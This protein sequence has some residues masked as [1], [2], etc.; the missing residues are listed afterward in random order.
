[1]AEKSQRS[2]LSRR[3]RNQLKHAE[4]GNP[5]SQKTDKDWEA[6]FA[7][8][9]IWVNEKH[10]CPKR[11]SKNTEEK[12]FATWVNHVQ[13]L[14]PLVNEVPLWPRVKSLLVPFSSQYGDE[15]RCDEPPLPLPKDSLNSCDP[16]PSTKRP[17]R[18]I[19]A[20]PDVDATPSFLENKNQFNEED[21]RLYERL[22]EAAFKPPDLS[23]C[24][25]RVYNG[26]Q[27][28]RKKPVVDNQWCELHADPRLRMKHG[29]QGNPIPPPQ[30]HNRICAAIQARKLANLLWYSR[31]HMWTIVKKSSNA[32]GLCQL[33]D[34][35]YIDALYETH[36]YFVK[37]ISARR[38]R[39][40]L[41][42]KTG[43]QYRRAWHRRRI[44]WARYDVSNI[45]TMISSCPYCK[46]MAC[47]LKLLPNDNL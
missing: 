12:K 28:C 37:H 42:P 46:R 30:L 16:P 13:Q 15:K 18:I 34:D 27:Q 17:R 10:E 5:R 38:R 24:R 4:N 8:L 45:I 25:A 20:R 11:N 29:V 23:C 14:S 6:E 47:L 3:A 33:S 7:L 43:P 44:T 22:R 1:M 32:D 21:Q 40:K 9:D 31:D 36:K 26:A 39:M 35:E 41:T 19:F 2:Y